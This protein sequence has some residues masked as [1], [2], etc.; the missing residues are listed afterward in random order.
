MFSHLLIYLSFYQANLNRICPFP[1]SIFR[2][3]E[4]LSANMWPEKLANFWNFQILGFQLQWS[5]CKSWKF[6]FSFL[7][8]FFPHVFIPTVLFSH[9]SWQFIL[10]SSQKYQLF[11]FEGFHFAQAFIF[12]WALIGQGEHEMMMIFHQAPKSLQGILWQQLLKSSKGQITVCSQ[13]A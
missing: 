7:T 8:D 12:N 3:I 11:T 1:A 13:L 4:F 9:P 6:L 2:L 5:I 10:S